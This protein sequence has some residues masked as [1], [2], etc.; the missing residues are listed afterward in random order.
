M[1]I[2]YLVDVWRVL[3]AVVIFVDVDLVLLRVGKLLLVTGVPLKLD[4]VDF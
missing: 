2:L 1:G 4:R 3:E